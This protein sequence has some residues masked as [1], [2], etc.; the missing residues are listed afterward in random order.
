MNATNHP[1]THMPQT[2]INNPLNPS[3]VGLVNFF[4]ESQ[5][6]LN[7]ARV[8]FISLKIKPCLVLPSLTQA[9]NLSLAIWCN[10]SMIVSSAYL[11]FVIFCPLVFIPFPSSSA[12]LI[13]YSVLMLNRHGD[14]I[15]PCRTPRFIVIS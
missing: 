3:G 5:S 14:N 10:S 11:M 2:S 1:Q 7:L 13:K 4:G 9:T 15:Q 6:R 8:F 12:S